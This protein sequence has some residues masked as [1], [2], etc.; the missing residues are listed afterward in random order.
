MKILGNRK[1]IAVLT[2][3]RQDYGVLRST[4]HSMHN[5]PELDMSLWVGGMHLKERFG[6]SRDLIHSEGIPIAQELDFLGEPPNPIEDSSRAMTMVGNV[7][8][9]ESPDA[10]LLVGDRSE[11]LAAGMAATLATVPIIHLHGGEET[12]GAIDNAMRHALTKLSH[13]HLVSHPSYGKRVEQMGED[14]ENVVVVGA[15]GL[16]NR[17]RDDLPSVNELEDFLGLRLDDPVVLVTVHPTTLGLKDPVSEVMAVSDA[18]D[19][20]EATYVVTLPNSD[21]GGAA[22][23]DYWINWSKDRENVS[24][25]EVLGARRYWSLLNYTKVMLGNSSSGMLEGPSA[26]ANVINVGDRQFGRLRN[27]RIRDVGVN[28]AEIT[29]LLEE[30]IEKDWL[31]EG[32]MRDWDFDERLVSQRI[33]EAIGKWNIDATL[34][35]KFHSI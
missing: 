28:S 23:R 10:L 7:L 2:T 32:E 31:L 16:D 1:R 18:M 24:L 34:R 30:A 8:V 21:A 4:V 17:F 25:K 15:P 19:K 35:K 27:S 20:V 14:P 12:E 13:L 22:I 11:T 5:D 26:G 33:I 6:T 3:G 29:R 9:S